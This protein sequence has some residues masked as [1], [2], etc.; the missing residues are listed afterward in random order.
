MSHQVTPG[1][2]GG[3]LSNFQKSY[4]EEAYESLLHESIAKTNWAAK[5][6]LLHIELKAIKILR[7]CEKTVSTIFKFGIDPQ[8]IQY[9][10]S[11]SVW[12]ALH[13]SIEAWSLT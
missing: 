2:H 7:N 6:R 12:V 8:V 11:Q 3:R 9:C 4:N 1:A 5:G 13:I 10:S